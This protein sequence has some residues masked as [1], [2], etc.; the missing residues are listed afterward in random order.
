MAGRSWFRRRR[1]TLTVDDLELLRDYIV[2]ACDDLV[3][4]RVRQRIAEHDRGRESMEVAVQKV[5]DER[6]DILTDRLAHILVIQRMKTEQ[7]IA[8]EISRL[9][10]GSASRMVLRHSTKEA[11]KRAV[12]QPMPHPVAGA[13]G[14]SASTPVADQ[15]EA[16]AA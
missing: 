10:A 16:N 7:L 15:V 9:E 11:D 4:I 14:R 12:V 1:S 3:D 2:G 5:I 8:E 13:A 6:F